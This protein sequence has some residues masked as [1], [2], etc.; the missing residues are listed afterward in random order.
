MVVPPADDGSVAAVD[1]PTPPTAVTS[2]PSATLAILSAAF[3]VVVVVCLVVLV[4][5][6]VNDT[7]GSSFVDR[8]QQLLGSDD[9]DVAAG[10]Y[11]A[12]SREAVMSQADQFMLRVFTY[13]PPDLDEQ[14]KMP[15]YADG[16]REVITPKAAVE[17]DKFVT[18][19]EQSVAQAGYARTV[20]LFS[21]GVDTIDDDTATVL[22]AGVFTSSYPDSRRKSGRAAFPKQP[23]RVAVT[24][25]KVDGDWLVDKF[26]PVTD[27]TEASEGDD[28]T[29]PPPGSPTTTAP[30]TTAPSTPSRTPSGPA[31]STGGSKP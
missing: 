29:T 4:V 16:I 22:V 14:N 31:T 3:A 11:D 15:E 30:P 20:Q 25:V 23:F 9:D 17:F 6:Y 10:S 18:L 13:G 21:T 1:D 26:E 5:R 7:E 24:L 8:T 28:I 12:S 19:A 2:R 27:G